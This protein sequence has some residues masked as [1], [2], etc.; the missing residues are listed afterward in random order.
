M[1]PPPGAPSLGAAPP[2]MAAPGAPGMPLPNM[3]APTPAL[4][5][6]VPP[7]APQPGMAP[8]QLPPQGPR[9]Y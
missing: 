6:G 4:S 5:P 1:M 3:P 7:M 9:G 8:G 2:Q